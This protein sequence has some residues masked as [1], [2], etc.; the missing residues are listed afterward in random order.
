MKTLSV[1]IALALLAPT[2]A[3]ADEEWIFAKAGGEIV[4]F[5]AHSASDEDV[6]TGAKVSRLAVEG[7]APKVSFQKFQVDCRAHRYSATESAGNDWAPIAND[8]AIVAFHAMF[9]S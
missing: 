8:K 1:V 5:D 4:G 6:I 7:A 9:C 3:L 2:A